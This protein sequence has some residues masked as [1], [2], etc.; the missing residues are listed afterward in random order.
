MKGLKILGYRFVKENDEIKENDLL[1]DNIKFIDENNKL[2]NEV[3]SLQAKV[4]AYQLSLKAKNLISVD[5]GDP[6][7]IEGDKRKN[8]VATVAGLHKDTLEPKLKQMIS[9]AHNL[10]EDETN[11]REIDLSLKGAIYAWR[12]LIH[13]GNVMV[14]EQVANQADDP[15]SS[16]EE[17]SD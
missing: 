14:N 7:P 2:K 17:N 9:V 13:W 4:D 3:S 6:A 8:Y 5:L 10:L 12:E 11:N 15:S 1:V 16:E